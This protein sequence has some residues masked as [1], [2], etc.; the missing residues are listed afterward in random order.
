[1]KQLIDNPFVNKAEDLLKAVRVIQ[2]AVMNTNP[3]IRYRLHWQAK[4][5][6]TIYI[7]FPAWLGDKL[8]LAGSSDLIPDGLSNQLKN[9]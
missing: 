1:M 8:L 4:L 5:M 6:F 9:Y 7:I 2:Y 3:K